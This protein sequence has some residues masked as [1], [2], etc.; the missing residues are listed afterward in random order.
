MV[1]TH[2]SLEP[3]ETIARF[4]FVY[5][6]EHFLIHLLQ[7]LPLGCRRYND[8]DFTYYHFFVTCC[9][10]LLEFVLFTTLVD[11]FNN[12]IAVVHLPYVT[13]H[14][15]FDAYLC[16]AC[17]NRHASS[18]LLCCWK[19]ASVTVSDAAGAAPNVVAAMTAVAVV[20]SVV[21][22][23]VVA[24]TCCAA[25]VSSWR[26]VVVVVAANAAAA[27]AVTATVVGSDRW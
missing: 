6:S 9:I 25:A 26:V 10:L 23:S 24:V 13:K 5:H 19:S 22:V 21:V 8:G 11:E 3:R 16:S 14:T 12:E 20:A 1:N 7:E 4:E 27:V 2:R 17:S 18:A 15:I